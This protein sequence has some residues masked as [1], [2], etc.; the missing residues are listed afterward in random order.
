MEKQENSKLNASQKLELLENVCKRQSEQI[1]ILASELDRLSNLVLALGKR[2]NAIVKTGDEGQQIN[3]KQVN[4][5]LILDAAR[6][7]EDKVNFLI[8]K[9]ILVSDNESQIN[10][11]SFVVGRETDS[12]GSEIN[13]RIQFAFKSLQKEGQD[14]VLGKK[15]GDV[16]LGDDGINMEIAQ[17]F[18][19]VEPKPD[20]SD[21]QNESQE[22]SVQG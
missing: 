10:E 7:L 15:V 6:E 18:T 1:E 17:I 16:V 8:E 19:I 22:V 12:S 5:L 14:K 9:G 11:M 13:P 21:E 2:V 3:S 4:D 20:F